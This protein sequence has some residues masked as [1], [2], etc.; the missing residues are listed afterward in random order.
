MKAKVAAIW[1]VCLCV[2]SG[3]MGHPVAEHEAEA[4]SS[5][6]FSGEQQFLILVVC[7]IV[8][9]VGGFF[10]N[11]LSHPTSHRKNRRK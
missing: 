7:G 8:L 2:V 11:K 1:F 10:I 9:V 5:S 6:Y 4:V 3:A